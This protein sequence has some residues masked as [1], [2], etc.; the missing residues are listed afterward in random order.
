MPDEDDDEDGKRE[1]RGEDIGEEERLR[2]LAPLEVLDHASDIAEGCATF[3]LE[4][5][6]ISNIIT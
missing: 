1:E 5:E 2:F 4:R 3:C 6:R